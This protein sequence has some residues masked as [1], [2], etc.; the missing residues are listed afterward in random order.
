MSI[1]I[2]ADICPRVSYFDLFINSR[3]DELLGEDLTKLLQTSDFNIFNLECPLADKDSPIEKLGPSFRAPVACA[4][5]LKSMRVNL[6]TLANNH[7]KDQNVEG[8]RSTI[9]ALNDVGIDYVG[10]G[11]NIEEARQLYTHSING[12][13]IG[14]Y[15]CAE[16]EFSIATQELAGANPF[17]PLESLE[18]IQRARKNSDYLIVLYHGGNEHY[19]YP[20]PNLQKV[21]RKIVENGADLVVCQHSHCIGCKEKYLTCT[22]IYGQGNFLSTSKHNH[23]CWKTS[24]LIEITDDLDVRYIPLMKEGYGVRIAAGDNASKIMGDFENRSNEIQNIGFVEHTYKNFADNSL[25]GYIFSFTGMDTSIISRFL[26][27]VSRGGF[28]IHKTQKIKRRKAVVY[29]D[30]IECESHRE[31]F[32]KGLEE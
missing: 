27:K 31:L 13:T 18:H 10:A 19:R 22:I 14:I 9:K 3:T 32:L 5:G 30:Y 21:C 23:E 8:V 28:G 2:G 26:N 20:S 25:Q 24:L 15:A 16:H 11:R 4:N 6:V 7:I 1:L 29:R 17:D 12:K